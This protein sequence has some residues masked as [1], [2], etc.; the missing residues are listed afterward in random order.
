MRRLVMVTLAALVVLQTMV[1]ALPAQPILVVM[2]ACP[3]GSKRPYPWLLYEDRDLDGC[4]DF[5]T[6]GGCDGSAASR[7]LGSTSSDPLQPTQWDVVIGQLG[8]N[9][10]IDS[11]ALHGIHLVS[12]S[13]FYAWTV[14]EYSGGMAVCSYTRND[15]GALFST[16]P[17]E[18]LGS[19]DR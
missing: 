15:N 19:L 5:V 10:G 14:T 13:G 6:V 18:E 12:G 1:L 17:P 11:V 7:P 4:Y 8:G 3:A 16:C 2:S 9:A